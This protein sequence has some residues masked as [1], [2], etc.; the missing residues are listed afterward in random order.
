MA[1]DLSWFGTGIL[2]AVNFHYAIPIR[3][4]SKGNNTVIDSKLIRFP[5]H[6]I[7][8]QP[9]HTDTVYTDQERQSSAHFTHIK[10]NYMRRPTKTTE[11]AS[12][13]FFYSATF[14]S[15]H[16]I[17]FAL[18]NCMESKMLMEIIES[19]HTIKTNATQTQVGPGAR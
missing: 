3:T 11:Q 19:G 12:K 4:K 8:Y 9:I 15:T 16:N 14:P 13:L 7:A 17:L 6:C 10:K 2:Y 1:F 5:C 18:H